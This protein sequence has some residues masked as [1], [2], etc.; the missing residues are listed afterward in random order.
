MPGEVVAWAC[1]EFH[2]PV[3]HFIYVKFPYRRTGIGSVLAA[4]TDFYTHKTRAGALL[5]RKLGALYNPYLLQ[6]SR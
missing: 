2:R 3:T 6:E 4:A 1:R 5:A